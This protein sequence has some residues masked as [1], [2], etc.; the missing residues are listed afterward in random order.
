MRRFIFPIGFVLIL[1]VALLFVLYP[2][3]VYGIVS[4][5][6]DG[7]SISDAIILAG[8]RSVYSDQAGLYRLGWIHSTPTLTVQANG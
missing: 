6:L 4:D 2:R 8:E 7:G 3:Q 5:E 1:I